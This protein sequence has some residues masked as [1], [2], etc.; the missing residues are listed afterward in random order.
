MKQKTSVWSEAIKT[1]M[2]SASGRKQSRLESLLVFVEAADRAEE[3]G[4]GPIG[5][6]RVSDKIGIMIRDINS[7]YLFENREV[8]RS[9]LLQLQNACP[10]QVSALLT[11]DLNSGQIR[12][13]GE[14]L[15]DIRLEA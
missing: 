1:S 6:Q 10:E 14:V 11:H 15:T 8:S 3:A 2:I 13:I 7:M 4:Y 5:Y 9:R 12:S